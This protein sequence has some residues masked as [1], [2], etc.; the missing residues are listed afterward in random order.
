[1]AIDT[2]K[3]R[4]PQQPQSAGQ[5]RKSRTKAV[6]GNRVEAANALALANQGVVGEMQGL[7]KAA[8]DAQI[9]SGH[10]AAEIAH[11]VETGQLGWGAF[12]QRMAELR[13]ERVRFEPQFATLNVNAILPSVDEMA[14]TVID[15]IDW[16]H[17]GA[18]ASE[19]L[20]PSKPSDKL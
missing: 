12:Q 6:T 3:L 9:T 18:V 11:A 16:Q 8:V 20:P 4:Q 14:S 15:A 19:A 10:Q 17:L 1:M 7:L 13:Q 2:D 5:P